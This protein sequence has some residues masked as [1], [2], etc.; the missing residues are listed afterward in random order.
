[1]LLGPTGAGKTTTLRLVA[2]LETADDGHDRDRRRATSRA[3]RRPRAMSPSSSSN[4]RSIRISP[5]STTWPFRCAR[6]RGAMPRGRDRAARATRSRAMLRIDH[7][8][9]E[10]RDPAL[11]RRD[12]ARRDRPGAGAQPVDLPD[13]RA[14]LLARRQAA[15]RS[16][17]R[18][19]AH[20]ERPRR[21]HALRHPRPDRGDDHGR[22][23]RRHRRRAGWS[24]SARRARSTTTRRTSMSRPGSASR[25]INLLPAGLL[26]DA[27]AAGRRRRRSAP[28][29][30]ICAS[31]GAERRS[32]TARIDWV[33]HLGDQNH[34][35]VE[36]GGRKIV[37]LT[38]PDSG[39][40]SRRRGG[41]GAGR[42]A[43]LRRRPATRI[44]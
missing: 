31:Q 4:I 37:S 39:V 1:M 44:A 22:P 30:S 26:P 19:Q 25:Q 6:R 11:R 15:R 16:A 36:L 20:P 32:A 27:D 34:L 3:R 42:A 9:A 7:K 43:V 18:T 17:P 38:D 40:R 23:H 24:R 28:A 14:A 21:D 5:C 10:P 13:G 33:E 41:G 8:L 12:A 2:G 35:H 29:P